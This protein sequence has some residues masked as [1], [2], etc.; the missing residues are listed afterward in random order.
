M[1]LI[2]QVHGLQFKISVSIYV[3]NNK[4][5]HVFFVQQ[6]K[7]ALTFTLDTNLL[8]CISKL[9]NVLLVPLHPHCESW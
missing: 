8:T 4:I 2:N 9:S 3:Y 5:S 6:Q 1:L 7:M